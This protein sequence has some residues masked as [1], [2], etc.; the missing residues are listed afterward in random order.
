MI[1][2]YNIKK[3]VP[4]LLA[5]SRI[6]V[7]I[8]IL[9]SLVI[10]IFKYS[11]HAPLWDSSVYILMGKHIY[12]CGTSGLWQPLAG[13]IWPLILGLFWR[14]GGDSILCGRIIGILLGP[15]CILLTYLIGK[16]VFSKTT[17]IIAALFFSLSPIFFVWGNY[18]YAD[19]PAIFFGL[20]SVYL[21]V[22]QREF[23]SG[24]L[25][26]IA[27]LTKFIQFSIAAVIMVSGIGLRKRRE[28]GFKLSRF[29]FGF[30]LLVGP[31]LVLNLI[32]YKNPFY[33][34]I[35]ATKTLGEYSFL[36]W[37]GQLYYIKALLFHENLCLLFGLVGAFFIVKTPRDKNKLM[38]FLTGSLF[39]L[40][41][42]M[43]G[44]QSLRYLMP[45]LPYVYLLS[46]YGIEKLYDVFKTRRLYVFVVL[47]VLAA[48]L[49]FVR[50]RQFTSYRFA[51][52]KLT[53]FQRYIRLNEDRI[54]GSVWISNPSMLVYSN[55]KASELIYY[56]L[57]D[58][59]KARLLYEK[60]DT[61]DLIL[62]NV[63]DFPCTPP[64]DMKC[65]TAKRKLIRAIESNFHSEW[66]VRD[67]DGKLSAGI[68]VKKK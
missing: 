46:G 21:I 68:F 36:W 34:I 57:F 15:A 28:S 62:F 10:R 13:V 27:S 43:S 60:L 16:T 56:P 29:V 3:P 48:A 20:L 49:L 66:H 9:F 18:L 67:R 5:P 61:A 50:G 58:L 42:H 8:L 6:L 40:C 17:G 25:A 4:T 31:F 39:L 37:K 30:L 64:D 52:K 38:I 23:S 32:L 19:I 65:R 53:V 35:S 44:T 41:I 11:D 2:E 1:P 45:A 22:R 7:A 47:V 51:G 33:P 59:H 55:L 54:K 26:A 63:K 14:I 24:I 12:S